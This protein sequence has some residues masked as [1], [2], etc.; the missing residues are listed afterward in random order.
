MVSYARFLITRYKE[1]S[2]DL[3]SVKV[4]VE[5]YQEGLKA[6][7]ESEMFYGEPVIE[8]LV[9]NTKDLSGELASIFEQYV[10]E[11]PLGTNE[12]DSNS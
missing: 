8:K 12:E 10:F 3:Y 1:I 5:S 2:E 9:E 7:Y 6:V 11:D 4:L